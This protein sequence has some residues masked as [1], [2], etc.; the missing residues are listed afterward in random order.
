MSGP[1]DST[2]SISAPAATALSIFGNRSWKGTDSN[3]RST[4]DHFPPSVLRNSASVSF[5]AAIWASSVMVRNFSVTGGFVACAT[6]GPGGEGDPP[7]GTRSP[8]PTEASTTWT[9]R[10][11]TLAHIRINITFTHDISV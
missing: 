7:A 9:R 4:Y 5:Q 6:T 10:T 11:V 8:M 3:A 1:S 2:R